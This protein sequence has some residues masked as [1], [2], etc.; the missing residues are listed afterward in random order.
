MDFD[1]H[2]QGERVLVAVG[3]GKILGFASVWEPESFLH[4]LFVHPAFKRRGVGQALLASC[5]R[6]FSG[7]PR[8]KCLKANL[9]AIRFYKFQG[10]RIVREEFGPEGPYLLME[11]RWP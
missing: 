6:Y 4:N 3:E 10:W 1:E 5:A 9:D 7:T 11:G 2:T 8:L